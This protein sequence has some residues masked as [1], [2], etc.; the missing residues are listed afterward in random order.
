MADSQS[1][2]G[3]IQPD[4][5]FDLRQAFLLRQEQLLATLGV[6]RS[7][8]GHPVAIG[9]NFQAPTFW[10]TAAARKSPSIPRGAGLEVM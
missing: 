2:A 4:H 3:V 9:D 5:R 10:L 1:E 7:V 6:G 8:G